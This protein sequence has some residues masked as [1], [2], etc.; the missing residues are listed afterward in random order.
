MYSSLTLA[1]EI[2]R[3]VTSTELPVQHTRRPHTQPPLQCLALIRQVPRDF[4][5]RHLLQSGC[6][7]HLADSLLVVLLLLGLFLF[8]LLVCFLELL[9]ALLLLQLSR[10]LDV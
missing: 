1:T 3:A 10:E 4:R 6:L 5:S 9:Q 2:Y 7:P 8:F